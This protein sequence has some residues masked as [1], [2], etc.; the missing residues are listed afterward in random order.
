MNKINTWKPEFPI[1][2][3]KICF[4]NIVIASR[5]TGKT[6]LVAYLYR[7]FLKKYKNATK[8]NEN[9][10]DLTIVFTTEQNRKHY[11][12]LTDDPL[13]IYTSANDLEKINKLKKI[14]EKLKKQFGFQINV[15]IIFDDFISNKIKYNN[16]ILQLF[17][18]GRHWGLS[19]IF[20]TQSATLVS[21]DWRNNSDITFVLNQTSEQSRMYIIE[22]IMP[23]YEKREF[24]ENDKRG[25]QK[26]RLSKIY[27]NILKIQYGVMVLVSSRDIKKRG[28]YQFIAP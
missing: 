13:N 9:K 23:S 10:I 5:D 11:S 8:Y 12:K 17:A 20:I 18:Q 21:N 6:Y 25:A 2:E 16:E 1:R 14:Q 15:L 4:S 24:D 28:I 19:V 7:I 22:N 26:K 3:G 27:G